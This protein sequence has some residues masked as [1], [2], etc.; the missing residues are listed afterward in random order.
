MKPKAQF[1]PLIRTDI[2]PGPFTDISVKDQ[3]WD[4]MAHRHE[5]DHKAPIS[6]T[7]IHR[8]RYRR[9]TNWTRYRSQRADGPEDS[10]HGSKTDGTSGKRTIFRAIRY[11][12]SFRPIHPISP[13]RLIPIPYHDRTDIASVADRFGKQSAPKC[14]SAFCCHIPER[15]P[16]DKERSRAD[17]INT[18][19]EKQNE[20]KPRRE[21]TEKET[22]HNQRT[23]QKN[24]QRQ[25]NRKQTGQQPK[26]G[27]TKTIY[28]KKK[29]RASCTRLRG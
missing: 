16:S 25:L 28:T 21:Q 8:I 26:Q 5:V 13:G 11:R 6:E 15:I 27:K 2:G 7:F 19:R 3:V 10:R 23:S 12:K 20:K 4:H 9:W 29:P 1:G 22:T 24:K 14:C 17:T 18:S